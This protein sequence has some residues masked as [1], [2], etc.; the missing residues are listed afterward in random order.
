MPIALVSIYGSE[1]PVFEMHCRTLY[2]LLSE[3]T[4]EQSI[5]H[6]E[7]P[8]FNKHVEFAESKPYKEWWIIYNGPRAVGA[9]YITHKNEIGLFIFKEFI[10]KG[11]GSEALK[12]I[13][14]NNKH[15]TFYAN[16]SPNNYKSINFFKKHG[17]L[18]FSD[19]EHVQYTYVYYSKTLYASPQLSQSESVHE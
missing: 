1:K 6:R 5:S 3:R 10:S 18:Y 15:I 17:F 12:F 14:N 16:I 19:M 7:M 9:A 11:Y 13:L 2:R 8:S 4:V